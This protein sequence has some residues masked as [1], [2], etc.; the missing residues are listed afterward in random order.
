M[1]KMRAAIRRH[2]LAIQGLRKTLQ[3]QNKQSAALREKL[4]LV[5]EAKQ[6]E[7]GE[8]GPPGDKGQIGDAGPMGLQG[9]DGWRGPTGDKGP[10]GDA[11]SATQTSL[12]LLG[13]QNQL[14]GLT[15]QVQALNSQV[16]SM[17]SQIESLD[18][19]VESLRNA[20]PTAPVIVEPGEPQPPGEYGT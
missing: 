9:P 8:K 14:A 10:T 20:S 2:T 18:S 1:N 19:I 3:R 6:G 16:Q 12:D 4:K 11:G 5:T 17:G 7:R 15:R 13:V